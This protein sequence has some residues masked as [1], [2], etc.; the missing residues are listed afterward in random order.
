MVGHDKIFHFLAISGRDLTELGFYLCRIRRVITHDESD[1]CSTKEISSH[2]FE[3]LPFLEH[4]QPKVFPDQHD[5]FLN[6]HDDPLDLHRSV[7]AGM[8]LLVFVNGGRI[9]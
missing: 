3:P 9:R 1:A 5:E 7:F 2:S 4:Q 6:F 8:L